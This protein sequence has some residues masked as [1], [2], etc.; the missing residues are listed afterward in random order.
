MDDKRIF[1]DRLTSA[2]RERRMMQADLSAGTGLS[3]AVISSYTRGVSF[4]TVPTLIQIAD[5]L[6][7]STDYLLGRDATTSQT[8]LTS[9]ARASSED[10]KLVDLILQKY[11]DKEQ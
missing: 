8:L 10:K 6:S 7:V 2:L 5:Y 4:P 11:S 9:Y 1:A 3:S